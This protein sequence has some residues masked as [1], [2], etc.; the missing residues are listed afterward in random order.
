MIPP[1]G[2]ERPEG[3]FSNK[4]AMFID[5]RAARDALVHGDGRH[6]MGPGRNI[7]YRIHRSGGTGNCSLHLF[8]LSEGAFELGEAELYK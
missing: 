5:L 7:Q 8:I 2:A 1:S 3:F 6:S 4:F